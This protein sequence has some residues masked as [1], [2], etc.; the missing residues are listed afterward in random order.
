MDLVPALL[1]ELPRDR[2]IVVVCAAGVRSH[3]VATWLRLQGRDAVSFA[4]GAGALPQVVAGP[5]VGT[6]VT[7]PAETLVDGVRLGRDV[8]VEVYADGEGAPD[9]GCWARGQDAEGL[10]FAVALPPSG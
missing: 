2:R 8:P 7:L 5:R 3:G 1:P 10:P 4:P 9:G 6:R